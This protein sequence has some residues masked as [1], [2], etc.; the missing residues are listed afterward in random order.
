MSWPG[1]SVV[2]SKDERNIGGVHE[3]M[4]V[5]IPNTHTIYTCTTPEQ[6]VGHLWKDAFLHE[7]TPGAYMKEVSRRVHLWDGKTPR[8]DNATDFLM[9][10]EEAGLLEIN[11]THRE[12]S[13]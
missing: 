2:T 7:T 1:A 4:R 10:L 5:T 9:D 6:A 3:A 12:V 8:C 11:W 13:V